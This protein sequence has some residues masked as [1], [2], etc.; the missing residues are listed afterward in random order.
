MPWKAMTP[1]TQRKDFVEAWM[2]GDDG[3]AAL[4]RRFGISRKTGY[5]WIR[6]AGDGDRAFA[7]RSRRPLTH[8]QATE[9]WLVDGIV[10]M[11]KQRPTWGPKK[12]RSV[13]Q[14]ANPRMELPA[15]S[16]FAA[17]LKRHGLIRPRRKRHR[18]PAF[19]APLQ[20]ARGPNAVWCIDFKGHF[21]VGTRRCYPLTITDAHSRYLIA[22][23]AL[24]NTKTSTVR[25]AMEQIFR[26]FG[27]PDAIRSDNGEPF[28][29]TGVAALT[30]LS[31]WWLKLDIR[32]ERIEP[33]HPEQNGRHERFHLTLKQ[34]TASPPQK[35]FAA[36]QRAFDLFRAVYNDQ[37]PHEALGMQTPTSCYE[38]SRRPLPEPPWG[39]DF[40]Y[41]LDFEVTRVSKLGRVWSSV[42]AFFLSS[43]LRYERVGIEWTRAGVWQVWFG[44]L[45]LGELRRPK[46]PSRR[47]EFT[48]TR[49][50]LPMS[51]E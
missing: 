38:P 1:M 49:T 16:T 12:L 33:G 43:A 31:A 39:R 7:D 45:L 44:R 14:A 11:R 34:E 8:P 47:V 37:R 51:P 42:G 2:R 46:R 25:R 35:T 20:H 18:S 32:H 21:A 5:K 9:S 24:R 29:S 40:E 13:L 15:L 48:P 4:C 26:E 28:A 6:R 17:I 22:C 23:V 50:V 27:L 3:V 36:Q 41:P 19:S 10:A 30:Q